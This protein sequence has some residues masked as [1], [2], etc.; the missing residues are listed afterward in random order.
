MADPLSPEAALSTNLMGSW[1]FLYF[2][3]YEKDS[4]AVKLFVAFVWA[5]TTVDLVFSIAS[6][7]PVLILHWGSV[8]T[9]LRTQTLLNHHGWV[10]GIVAFSVQMFFVYRIHKFSGR[11]WLFPALIFPFALWELV[12][13]I[14]LTIWL[15]QQAALSDVAEMRNVKLEIAGR[16]VSA[17]VDIMITTAMVYLLARNRQP[18]IRRSNKM[19]YRLIIMTVNTGLWTAIIALVDVAL[20]AAFPNGLQLFAVELPL[21]PLYLN[22]LLANLNVR[23]LVRNV[24]GRSM[25]LESRIVADLAL[26]GLDSRTGIDYKHGHRPSVAIRVDTMHTIH[27]SE[28]DSNFSKAGDAGVLGRELTVDESIQQIERSLV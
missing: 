28:D 19:I 2:L 5:F 11:K 15:D 9:L 12:G 6:M 13:S 17:F 7:F 1:G 21:N 25:S 22:M 3:I 4:M 24:D 14:L 27:D 23:R 18:D 20:I 26:V 16:S 8:D 10:S